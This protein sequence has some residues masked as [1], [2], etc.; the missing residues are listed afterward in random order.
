LLHEGLVMLRKLAVEFNLNLKCC[1]LDKTPITEE[2]YEMMGNP[3]QYN[4]QVHQA[5]QALASRLPTFVV[6][7]DGLDE[8][9]Q[10]YLLIERGSFWGMGYLEKNLMVEN[11]SKLKELIEPMADNDFIRNSLYQ[12][13]E[14]H[15]EKKLVW[16][17]EMA[18]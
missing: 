11:I 9:E 16:A 10:L 3:E 18:V 15:P 17:N 5:L 2:D 6:V 12:Y 14:N 1:L 7:D 4:L 8:H 13:V